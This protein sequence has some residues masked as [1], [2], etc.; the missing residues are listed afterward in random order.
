MTCLSDISDNLHLAKRSLQLYVQIVSKAYQTNLVGHVDA[1]SSESTAAL[2]EEEPP[3]NSV[4]LKEVEE[5][6]EGKDGEPMP[7]VSNLNYED[8]DKT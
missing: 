1:T 3:V 2:E 5:E 8:D 7:Y 6:A 4:G